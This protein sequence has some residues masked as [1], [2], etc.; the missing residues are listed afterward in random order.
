MPARKNI[1]QKSRTERIQA[2]RF[3]KPP[4]KLAELISLVNCLPTDELRLSFLHP[5]TLKAQAEERI[6]GLL[7]ED[8][9]TDFFLDFHWS[10]VVLESI[11]PLPKQLYDY[12][13]SGRMKEKET[14]LEVFAEGG[15][16]NRYF[17]VWLANMRLR[18]IAKLATEEPQE[19]LGYA[20]LWN[21]PVPIPVL[22]KIDERGFV[23]VS[24]D[25]FTEAMDE[26]DVEA[27]RIR[28]C[29]VCKL[30]FWAGRI[31]QRGCSVRCAH[32]IRK[33]RY[34]EKYGQGFYQG[35]KL[36]D[37]EKSSTKSKPKRKTKKGA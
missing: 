3:N 37:K 28:I 33:R 35:A 36:S 6:R 21:Q 31:N 22:D 14:L 29:E 12:V 20:V 23:R 4:K 1:Q 13:F 17:N 7:G 9:D 27:A 15:V 32:I 24:K 26:D 19:T 18:S 34:R 5:T 11:E 8:V 10:H 16:V 2:S 25:L 30:L